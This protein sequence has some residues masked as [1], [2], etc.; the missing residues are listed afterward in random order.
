M[1]FG[2]KCSRFSTQ[3]RTNI[4]QSVVGKQC[5]HTRLHA[6]NPLQ[7][8]AVTDG[9]LEDILVNFDNHGAVSHLA[10]REKGQVRAFAR[11]CGIC[12]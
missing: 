6:Y 2:L 1:H 8:P 5:L 11:V 12:P 9:T 4:Y 3:R 10:K 7:E